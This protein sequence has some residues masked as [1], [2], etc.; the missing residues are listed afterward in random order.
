MGIDVHEHK[1]IHIKG[2]Y[3]SYDKKEDMV[4][5]ISCESYIFQEEGKEN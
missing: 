2:I 5:K 1:K 4:I 3:G